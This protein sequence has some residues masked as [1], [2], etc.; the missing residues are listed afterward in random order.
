MPKYRQNYTLFKRGKYYYYRTYTPD[1]VRTGAHS[2]GCK[3]LSAARVYCDELLKTGELLCFNGKTFAEY[4]KGF[5]SE[6]SVYVK[7]NMLAK[8]SVLVYNSAV[9]KVF[10]PLI[11]N[12]KLTD[13]TF[14]FLK[15]LRQKMLDKGDSPSTVKVRMKVLGIVIKSAYMDGLIQKNPFDALKSLKAETTSRDAFTLEEIKSLY[16]S[17]PDEAKNIILLFALTGMRLAELAAV[18]KEELQEKDGINFIH[19]ERQY[20]QEFLPLKNK[21]ARDIPLSKNLIQLVG[22]YH[23]NLL[24][25][26]TRSVT[27]EIK[28][29]EGWKE[30][31]LCIHSFRHFFISSA[32]SY[33]INHLKVEAI[34]G[35][36]LKGIQEVYTTFHVG[37]LAEIIKWQEWAY[38][39]ITG[40]EIK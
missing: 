8:A 32:K 29:I 20:R 28:K 21:K 4:A 13:I 30:R 1:G 17:V 19:L 39:Q 35:H 16:F 6:N 11:G 33:G 36:S 38:C 12:K 3:S 22:S 14:S 5:F 37:D 9:E 34:A 2:T 40:N 25:L 23:Y 10:I 26:L 7:D 15:S 27:P 31:K 24:Q 18:S